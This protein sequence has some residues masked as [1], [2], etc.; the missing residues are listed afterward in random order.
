M[1]PIALSCRDIGDPVRQGLPKDLLT[2]WLSAREGAE[3]LE[4]PLEQ[5]Q[6]S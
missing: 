3:T 5:K 1:S 6:A 2:I 4:H